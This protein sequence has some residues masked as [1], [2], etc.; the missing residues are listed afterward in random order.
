MDLSNFTK[1]RK[2]LLPYVKKTPLIRSH[3]LEELLG[4]RARVFLKCENV[5]ATNS[6]KPRGAFT[7][8]LRLSAEEKKR[9]VITRSAGNFAQGLALAGKTLDI[10]TTIVMPPNVPL[11]KKNQT[12]SYGAKIILFGENQQEEQAKAL[13]IAKQESLIVLSPYD[14]PDVIAGQ[15]TISLE[16][17]ENLPTITHFF[18]P[19]GGGGLMAGCASCFKNLNPKI[20]VIAVEPTAA[21][22]YFLSRQAGQR[23]RNKEVN[24]IADGLRA[25]QVGDHPW[26]LLQ[27]N[28]DEAVCVSEEEI[29]RTMRFIYEKHGLILEPSG[30]VSVAGLIFHRTP[31]H[32]DV[33]C[34]LSGANVDKERFYEWVEQVDPL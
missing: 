9:G 24:T 28:V 7:V 33:V 12:A 23:V 32:G 34:V 10:K 4:N 19:V 17:Y 14:H 1:A 26:P 22:D 8:L 16:V 13:E 27:K 30:A 29:K 31:L 6:F 11:V 3:A 25:P 18:C 21:N 15:G 2:A 5:Q 20:H